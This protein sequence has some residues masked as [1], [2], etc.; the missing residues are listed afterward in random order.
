M[1]DSSFGYMVMELE[2]KEVIK[3][4]LMLVIWWIS[5]YMVL[6]GVLKK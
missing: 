4:C 1:L 3:K 5:S 2:R 6:R